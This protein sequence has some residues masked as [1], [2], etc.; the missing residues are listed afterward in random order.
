MTRKVANSL[1][2][3]QSSQRQ[4]TRYDMG[5]AA[6]N[7]EDKETCPLS[8]GKNASLELPPKDPS[9]GSVQ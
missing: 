7:H 2:M 8:F 6:W 3:V 1:G 9:I 4:V 5:I